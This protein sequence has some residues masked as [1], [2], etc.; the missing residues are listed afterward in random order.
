M[1]CA[2]VNMA[3]TDLVRSREM[4]WRYEIGMDAPFIHGRP[5]LNDARDLIERFGENAQ[6][7]AA[8]RAA[9]SR[10]EGNVRRFCH[11]RQ[12]QRVIPLLLTDEVHGTVH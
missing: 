7:E 3:F 2:M 11:W 12:I 6:C 5:A 4:A 1:P 10:D 9:R 8:S